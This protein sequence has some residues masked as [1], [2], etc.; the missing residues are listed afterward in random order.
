MRDEFD[1]ASI[2][3]DFESN[4]KKFYVIFYRLAHV[5][6]C[7]KSLHIIIKSNK[8]MWTRASVEIFALAL[9]VIITMA[10]KI[11][12]KKTHT[13]NIFYHWK[14]GWFKFTAGHMMFL[15]EMMNA[16]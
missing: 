10:K 1:H 3:V 14:S 12:E 9:K 2:F 16:H 13:T 7:C 15:H 5:V 4:W 6:W 11:T 8:C